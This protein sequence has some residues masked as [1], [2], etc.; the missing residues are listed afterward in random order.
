VNAFKIVSAAIV[1]RSEPGG[2]PS[3]LIIDCRTSDYTGR[4]ADVLKA[5]S[6]HHMSRLGAS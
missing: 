4:L 2:V 1:E 6:G 5:V 3:E